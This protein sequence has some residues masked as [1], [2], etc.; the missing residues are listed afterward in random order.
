L[1]Y[2]LAICGSTAQSIINFCTKMA[3][4]FSLK[5]VLNA[6]LITGCFFLFGC[7][8]KLEDVQNI[9]SKSIGKDVAKDVAIKYTIRGKKKAILK[10]PVMYRVQDTVTYIEFINTVHV[11]FFNI[12]DSIEST[13][14]AMYAKYNDGQSKIFLKDS[15]RIINIIGD[16]LFCNELYWDRS[17][18]GQEFYTDKPVRIRRKTEI[19][20]GTAM[21][22]RQ[23]FKEWNVVNPVGFLRVKS[24]DFPK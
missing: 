16:T 18:T 11:D 23:D 9:N 8:N 22:A 6:A 24:V 17:K 14:D 15:V 20:D 5:I 21:Q 7:E 10:G 1:A 3:Q 4:I 13:L 2:H 12:N 19:I